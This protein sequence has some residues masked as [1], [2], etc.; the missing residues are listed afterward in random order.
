MLGCTHGHWV[1]GTPYKQP[2]AHGIRLAP[3]IVYG[4]YTEKVYEEIAATKV[5]LNE[6]ITT[7]A[8]CVVVVH[9]DYEAA[10]AA[11]YSNIG[12]EQCWAVFEVAGVLYDPVVQTC[13]FDQ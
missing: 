9:R 4:M 12:R 6:T 1:M 8:E 13:V 7:P 10:K 3:T 11:G 2:I 5:A